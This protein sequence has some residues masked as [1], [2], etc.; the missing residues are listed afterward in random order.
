LLKADVPVKVVG[1]RLGHSRPAITMMVYQLILPGM[2]ADAAATF[3]DAV[4]ASGH[5]AHP[6]Q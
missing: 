1:E 6:V 5:L 3:G 2:H 4:S